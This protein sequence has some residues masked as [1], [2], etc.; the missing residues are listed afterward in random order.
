VIETQNITLSPTANVD[1]ASLIPGWCVDIT[2]AITCRE[3]TQRLKITGVSVTED[4]GSSN[5]P[6]QER[7]LLQV[8]AT[9][10]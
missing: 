3:L 6:G 2:T 4:G 9:A 5:D 1:L 10:S 7:V 8:A